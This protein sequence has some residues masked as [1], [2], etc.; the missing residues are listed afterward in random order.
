MKNRCIA[1]FTFLLVAGA[2]AHAG[3]YTQTVNYSFTFEEAPFLTFDGFDDQG[4]ALQLDAMSF[5]WNLNYAIDYRVENT[6]P[7]AVAAGD[8]SMTIDYYNIHQ[9]G[10]GDGFPAYG[11]GGMYTSIEDVALAAYDPAPGGDDTHYGEYAFGYDRVLEFTAVDD[12]VFIEAMVQPGEIE[13]V[14][15]GFGG[16][17]FF[18]INEPIGWDPP[19]GP[20]G[21]PIYPTDDAIW[22]FLESTRHFGTVTLTYEYSEVPEPTTA[23]LV[24][25]M[26]LVVLRRRKLG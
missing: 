16:I 24:G 12:P 23:V 18:W 6:G 14:Y 5:D 9:L 4:G 15:G 26:S 20:F 22:L 3:T 8:F 10:I 13:T 25:A 11:S 2:T 1:A 19:S 17:Q 7:T 21:E